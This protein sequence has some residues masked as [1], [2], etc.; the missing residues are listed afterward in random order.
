MKG[1]WPWIRLK[2]ICRVSYNYQSALTTY[3]TFPGIFNG[4][5]HHREKLGTISDTRA[6]FRHVLWTV[7]SC[8]A[9]FELFF[10]A[11]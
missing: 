5:K 3:K 7:S 1:E 8:N 10:W 4:T 9:L 11:F 2:S 6:Y